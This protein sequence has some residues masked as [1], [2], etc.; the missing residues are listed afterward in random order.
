[1][2]GWDK[3]L[4]GYP[5][6]GLRLDV[7]AI[8]L[9]ITTTGTDGSRIACALSWPCGGN[10]FRL[11]K[12]VELTADGCRTVSRQ[13][14]EIV[15]HVHLIVISQSM[16]DVG[17]PRFGR[18]R[19]TSEGRLEPDDPGIKLG[20]DSDLGAKAPL[21]LTGPQPCVVCN[22]GHSNA[23]AAGQHS[24]CGVSNAADGI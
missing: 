22:I 23:S 2:P 3:E 14:I 7:Q 11:H 16:G 6:I 5:A 10:Y 21:E 17:P 20:R 18:H 8:R 9:P 15:H 4:P 1:M 19:L 24:R 12:H 13:P